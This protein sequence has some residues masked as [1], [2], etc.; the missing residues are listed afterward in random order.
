[1]TRRWD[2]YSKE[3]GSDYAVVNLHN[4]KPIFTLHQLTAS[5]C[6]TYLIHPIMHSVILMNVKKLHQDIL[7]AIPH[8]PIT[9]EHLDN[10]DSPTS[11]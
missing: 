2:I 7:T 3:V 6:T 5:I 1:M 9:K 8:D 11:L 10:P 4:F